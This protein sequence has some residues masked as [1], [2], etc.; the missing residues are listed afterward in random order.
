[1]PPRI[2]Q[3]INNRYRIDELIAKGGFGAVYRA[4]DLNLK[5]PCAVKENLETLC[6]AILH[7]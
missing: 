7:R 1:M 3:I 2:G 6:N 5:R 4:Y